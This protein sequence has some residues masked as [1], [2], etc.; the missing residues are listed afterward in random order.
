MNTT[1]QFRLSPET[2]DNLRALQAYLD[3]K[4]PGVKHTATDA[5][6]YALTTTADRA[7][8]ESGKT[9]RKPAKTC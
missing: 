2:W 7:R 1:G 5:V 9:S 8:K 4:I 6:V 3:E